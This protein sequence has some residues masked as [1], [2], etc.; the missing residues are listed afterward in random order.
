MG[1]NQ[2]PLACLQVGRDAAFPIGQHARD[3]ILQALGR[4]NGDARIAAVL[5]QVEL[6]ARFQHR[7][8]NVEA[9]APD[10]DLRVAMLG[11]RLRLVQAGQPAIVTLVQA[12][13]LLHRQPQPPHFLQRQV[14][15]LDRAGLERGIALVEI[16][17]LGLHQLSR[18]PR[19]ARALLGHVHVPPSG[20]AVFQIP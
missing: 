4:W 1:G 20:E 19:F 17:P 5:A 11:R 14:Q 13:V 9:A 16:Q 12:P 6:A 3:R 8:R 2:H 18:R 7:R 15:R 10:L